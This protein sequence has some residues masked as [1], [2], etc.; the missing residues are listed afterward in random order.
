MNLVM[1]A[2]YIPSP[3]PTPIT[4]HPLYSPR[5]PQPH[6]ATPTA[7]SQRE[8][9]Q[10]Q[11]GGRAGTRRGRRGPRVRRVPPLAELGWAAFEVGSSSSARCG[12]I[13][14]VPLRGPCIGCP[15]RCW[16]W[17]WWCRN[18]SDFERNSVELCRRGASIAPSEVLV[19]LQ[20]LIRFSRPLFQ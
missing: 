6:R 14:A 5:L 4:R 19:L 13:P 9:Q 18:F 2:V 15:Q 10:G 8:S 1:I 17:W 12:S 11:V 7:A 20:L 16:C 3:P